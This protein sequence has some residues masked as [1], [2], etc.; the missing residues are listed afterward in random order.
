[1]ISRR[2]VLWKTAVYQ[3]VKYMTNG[4]ATRANVVIAGKVRIRATRERMAVSRRAP[5]RGKVVMARVSG[6]PRA[7]NS[8]TTSTS[9]TVWTARA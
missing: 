2:A 7:R 4:T 6:R 1:M 3:D 8:G 5:A 9:S